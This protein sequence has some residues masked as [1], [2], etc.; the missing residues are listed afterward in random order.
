VITIIKVLFALFSILT[1]LYLITSYA[2]KASKAISTTRYI[3][4][5]TLIFVLFIALYNTIAVKT[6]LFQPL[7]LDPIINKVMESFDRFFSWLFDRLH[8]SGFYQWLKD[9]FSRFE[10]L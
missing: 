7:S 6:G 1:V 2:A 8:L 9:V 4:A 5:V 10:G 3:V